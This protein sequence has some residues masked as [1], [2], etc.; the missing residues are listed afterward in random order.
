MHEAMSRMTNPRSRMTL[1]R[2]PEEGRRKEIRALSTTQVLFLLT[3]V[4]RQAVLEPVDLESGIVRRCH[5][6]LEVGSTGLGH[7]GGTEEL[8]HDARRCLGARVW[9]LPVGPRPGP[10]VLEAGDV[11]HHGVLR[12]LRRG[13]DAFLF[14]YSAFGM[15]GER[16]SEKTAM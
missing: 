13:D 16:L 2:Q 8:A 12:Q 1:K 15:K 4:Q 6:G 3:R 10:R 5:A 14:Q 9:V 7:A 11:L